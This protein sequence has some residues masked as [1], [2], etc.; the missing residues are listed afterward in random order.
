MDAEAWRMLGL[1]NQP[2]PPQV[3][4]EEESQRRDQ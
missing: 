3:I 4:C 1:T 2:S